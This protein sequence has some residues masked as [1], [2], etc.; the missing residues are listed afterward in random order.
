[1]LPR[2]RPASWRPRAI[3]EFLT[4]PVDWYF[5]LALEHLRARP[6]LAEQRSTCPPL[7][8]RHLRRPGRRPRHAHRRRADDE[9]T[10]VELRAAT[11]S[12][13]SSPTRST[14]CCSSS[15][16]GSADAAAR[17]GRLVAG[18]CRAWPAAPTATTSAAT[19]ERRPSDRRPRRP[20]AAATDAAD[21][22]ARAPPPADRRASSAPSRPGWRCRGASPSCRTA[23]PW[24]PSATR[25]RAAA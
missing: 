16:S 14:S 17:R 6:G 23:R 22:H 1:M 20:T 7:R 11:S 25:A 2:A 9:A 13:W 3:R 4:T 24:S 15:S 8:R 12:R 21:P 10:Y 5:H 19:P 18:R